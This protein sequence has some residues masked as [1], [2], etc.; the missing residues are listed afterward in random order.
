MRKSIVMVITCSQCQR[1]I[2][3]DEM[4]WSHKS[5]A[6]CAECR[7][8][9]DR[10]CAKCGGFAPTGERARLGVEYARRLKELGDVLAEAVA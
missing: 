2:G 3:G 10:P 9:P 1:G 6:V 7:P 5:H 4:A 8:T